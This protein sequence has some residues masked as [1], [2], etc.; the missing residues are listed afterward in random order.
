MINDAAA[1]AAV[2]SGVTWHPR[3]LTPAASQPPPPTIVA[4]DRTD[5]L[6]A[7]V[8]GG[9]VTLFRRDPVKLKL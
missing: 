3:P 7:R 5:S 4:I 1:A 8:P 9:A 6:T 2:S